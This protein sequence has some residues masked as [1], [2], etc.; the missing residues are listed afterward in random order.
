MIAV[1]YIGQRRYASMSHANHQALLAELEK[2]APVVKYD[3]TREI[4]QPSA[5]PWQQSGGIQIFDFLHR[6]SS[7]FQYFLFEKHIDYLQISMN[8][9]R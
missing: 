6:Q 9:Y 3:F 5:S 7:F 4:G 1:M 8:L 2:I